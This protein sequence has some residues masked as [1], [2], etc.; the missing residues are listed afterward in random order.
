VQT[1]DSGVA[2]PHVITH[3]FTAGTII[4]TRKRSYKEHVGAEELEPIVRKLMQ[5]QHKAMCIALRDGELDA[6]L[7]ISDTARMEPF[8]DTVTPSTAPLPM[9]E[10]SEPSAA[11]AV[12]EAEAEI[13]LQLD[14]D[15]DD[16]P[17]AGTPTPPFVK[18]PGADQIEEAEASGIRD[19]Q[20]RPPTPAPATPPDGKPKKPMPSK[21]PLER[22]QWVAEIRETPP[23]PSMVQSKPQLPADT[24]YK[25]RG[26]ESPPAPPPRTPGRTPLPATRKRVSTVPPPP[27]PVTP[28]RRA[29]GAGDGGPA[30][31]STEPPA[32][33]EDGAGRYSSKAPTLFASK[34]GP[35]PPPV[36]P[37]P[38][39]TR[40]P[41]TPRSSIFGQEYI[42]EK[43]LDEVILAYLSE[44]MDDK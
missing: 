39:E 34:R 19:K 33:T 42:S 41:A 20:S 26:R 14:D 5:E 7:P 1:E 40:R 3:V 27:R 37:P 12:A 6:N 8:R 22:P 28:G 11:Q 9:E 30:R 36:P 31:G 43:S 17:R 15:A 21:P 23:P 18:P 38:K 25:E 16:G 2:H 35:T 32:A 24:T 4:G 44:E 10:P 13:D 29:P